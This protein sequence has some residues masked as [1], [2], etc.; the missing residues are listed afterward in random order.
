MYKRIG[1]LYQVIFRVLIILILI[2]RMMATMCI[3]VIR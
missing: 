1:I 3:T 2:I